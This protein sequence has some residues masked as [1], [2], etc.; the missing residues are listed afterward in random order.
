M[1]VCVFFVDFGMH[2]RKAEHVDIFYHLS[3]QQF[4]VFRHLLP[5]IPTSSPNKAIQKKKKSQATH[6]YVIQK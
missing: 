2:Y 1:C 4:T 6:F 5:A 3:S